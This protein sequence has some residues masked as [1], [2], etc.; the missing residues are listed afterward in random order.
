MFAILRLDINETEGM[1]MIELEHVS[2]KYKHKVALHPITLS[3]PTGSCIAL[4]GGNGA[5]KSTIIDLLVTAI[6]PT[7]G[8]ITI[9]KLA[10]EKEDK[11]KYLKK[12]AYMPD[13]FEMPSFL[14]VQEFLQFYGKLGNVSSIQID[15][16]LVAIGLIE[17]RKERL[18]KL[19][20]GMRQRVLLGQALLQEADYLILDEPTN[21]LDPYWINQFISLI[22]EQKHQGRTIIF[23]THMMDVVAEIADQVVFLDKGQ[24][25][26]QFDIS[27]VS[28]KKSMINKL[29][30]AHR[31][32][33]IVGK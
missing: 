15:R 25:V 24:I 9:D 5:G 22:R 26:K 8:H 6:K 20:K 16:I 10:Y 13:N 23:S 32:Q 29:L 3:I 7:T 30:E 18:D 2:K 27:P 12:I 14:T 4:C 1:S 31:Q 11:K 17:E 33:H 19:S 28:N 21:G